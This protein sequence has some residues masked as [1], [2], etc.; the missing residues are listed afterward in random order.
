MAM[1]CES[2]ESCLSF[3]GMAGGGVQMVC[4]GTKWLLDTQ[5]KDGSWPV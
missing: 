4:H 2:L 5:L 1:P 3:H